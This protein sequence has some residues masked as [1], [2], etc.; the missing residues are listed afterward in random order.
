LAPY[1]FTRKERSQE[2][3]LLL[4][5]T[6]RDDGGRHHAVTNDVSAN[7]ARRAELREATKRVQ[8]IG[9]REAQPSVAPGEVR[10]REASIEL[11]AQELRRIRGRGRKGRDEF[12]NQGVKVGFTRGHQS[13]LVRRG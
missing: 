2:A 3:L 10:P 1:L 5:G 11:F 7:G 13:P 8:L 12:V 6:V 9:R 4:F